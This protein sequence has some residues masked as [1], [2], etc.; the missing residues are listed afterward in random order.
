MSDWVTHLG[1]AYIGARAAKI[2]DVQLVLFGAVLPDLLMPTFVLLDL[3]RVPISLHAFAYLL[4]FQSVTVVSLMAAG[5]S[6]FLARPLRCFLLISGGALTHFALDVLETDIDCG[7]RPLYPFVYSTWSPGWLAPGR[8]PSTVLLFF[9][10]IAIAVAVGQRAQLSP[11]LIKPKRKNLLWAVAL[12]VLTALV[13]LTT[14]QILVDKNVHALG[15]LANPAS[16]QDRPVDLCFSEVI[17]VT[18]A[19]IRELGKD[20]EL[21]NAQGLRLGE[22][23]SVRGLY[24]DGKIYPSVLYNHQGFSDAWISLAGVVALLALLLSGGAKIVR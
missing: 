24:R 7:L 11:L 12:M 19:I 13:P 21:A 17:E 9:S 4:P 23:I 22:Q 15:F 3:L 18:P 1:T 5:L 8:L 20:F 14:P 6:L 16:W 10:A 2:R